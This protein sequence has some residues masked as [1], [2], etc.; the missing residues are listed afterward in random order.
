MK[1]HE[2]KL[3]IEYHN[4]HADGAEAAVAVE[5]ACF[6]ANEA[7]T[8]PI[9]KERV[10]LAPELFMTATDGE[11]GKMVGFITAIATDECHLRDDFFTNTSL[12]NPGGKYLMI[13]SLAVLPQYRNRRIATTLMKELL[14]SQMGKGRKAAVLTCVPAN[15]A[16]Y[17]KM[18]FADQGVSDS[19]WGGEMWHEMTYSLLSL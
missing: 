16:L 15:V 10:R 1:Y 4:V 7:C 2:E 17:K 3:K 13:L 11:N 9:M 19:S 8:L 5:T 12:H 6:P 14:S 18:G